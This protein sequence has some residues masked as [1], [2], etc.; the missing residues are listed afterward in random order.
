MSES[1]NPT[2]EIAGD[3][4]E[5]WFSEIKQ[6]GCSDPLSHFRDN[7]YGQINLERAH[8]GGLAQFVTGRPALLSNLVRDPLSFLGRFQQPV[9]SRRSKLLYLSTS[10]L[11]LCIWQAV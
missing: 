11:T 8:P 2:Q 9:E 4:F 3:S 6:I 10:V 7:S 1:E 5:K